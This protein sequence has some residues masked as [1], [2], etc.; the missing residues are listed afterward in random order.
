MNLSRQNQIKLI[1]SPLQR[2]L[3]RPVFLQL[4][5]QG[6]PHSKVFV[7]Q[8]A[9]NAIVAQGT[10]RSKKEAK[11]AAARSVRDQINFDDLPPPPTFQSMMER[12][13]K[14]FENGNG[15]HANGSEMK[16]RKYDYARHFQGYMGGGPG[17]PYGYGMYKRI[18]SLSNTSIVV[19]GQLV[20]ENG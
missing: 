17:I 18:H 3:S 10:G 6:P 15:H 11:V 13:R 8:C 2:G 9:F 4:S 16:K 1:F 7:W 5:E 12:K 14:K 20:S 19:I